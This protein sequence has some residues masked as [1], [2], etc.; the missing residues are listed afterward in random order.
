MNDMKKALQVLPI[1][2]F[3]AFAS[4]QS[5]QSSL[6]KLNSSGDFVYTPDE[7]GNAI[8][9]FSAVGYFHGERDIPSVKSVQYVKPGEND[10]QRIQEAIDMVSKKPTDQY[11]FRGAVELL[12][13]TYK[14]PG[15][16][17]ID[18][19]GVILRG[20]GAE[21]K[22]IATGTDQRSLIVVAGTGGIKEIARTRKTILDQFI[23]CGAN[24]IRLNNT[25][26][27]KPGDRVIVWMQ[28]KDNWI[29]DLKM[30]SIV[31]AVDT[32][33]WTA[34]GYA[35]QFERTILGIKGNAILLDNPL[36]MELDQQYFETAVYAYQFTGRINQV[37][38]ENLTCISAYE[39]ET[40]E[41]HAWV[42][43]EMNKIE[44]GWVRNVDAFHF[45]YACVFLKDF[46]KNIT[47]QDSK[48]IDPKSLITGSRRYSFNNDGQQNLVQRCY[49]KGGRH[50]FVT[51]SRV[52]GP[53]VFYNC[54]AEKVNSD[55]G[56]HHRW[57]MGT[58]YD[59][60]ITDGDINVRDR[61]NM[62][63]GHGWVGVT[64]VLWN[65]MAAKIISQ[66]PWVSGKNY[67]IGGNYKLGE[68]KLKRKE[69]FKEGNG[70][71]GLMPESLYAAQL[72]QR[73]KQSSAR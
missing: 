53:N 11:G 57:T 54:K 39:A 34:Q 20:A 3:T 14:I 28:A 69:S 32:K 52:C 31:P 44:N 23:P 5:W 30:D 16:L 67:V 70:Q 18:S 68:Y 4:A 26:S 7:K 15:T 6:V 36:V 51:G 37:G 72:K 47:V 1:L 27:L 59:N 12:P 60:I 29:H 64:Q 17:H 50:D 48:M 49:A 41:N 63:S 13:G 56:P 58:L 43:I 8:P 38:I 46:A 2:F 73:L 22:L 42:A 21:T 19:S 55:I 62:G 45:G 33:Q 9:D 40:A 25:N 66:D 35:F 71:P 65:C 10:Q 24:A 61:G